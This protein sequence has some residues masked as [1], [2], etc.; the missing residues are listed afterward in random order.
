MLDLLKLLSVQSESYGSDDM[1][2]FIMEYLDSINVNYEYDKHQNIYAVIDPHLPFA[3]AHMDTVHKIF[4]G[5]LVPVEIDGNITGMNDRT[6]TQS[7]IGGDDK[8]GIYAALVLLTEG[9]CNAAFFVDEEVGCKGSNKADLS[10]FKHTPYVLQADRR[11]NSDFITDISGAISSQAFQSA[12]KPY[13]KE[14]GYKFGWGMM[15]DVEALSDLG[16]GVSVANMSCGYYNPHMDNEYINIQDLENC[17]SLMR[18][19]FTNVKRKFKFTRPR[20]KYSRGWDDD[21]YDGVYSTE[22]TIKGKYG[23][24]AYINNN[25]E[26]LTVGYDKY[27]SYTT[28]PSEIQWTEDGL[29]VGENDSNI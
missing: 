15:T 21:M 8:C 19:I 7:G 2:Q 14:H 18:A 3:V 17:I 12:I 20:R 26:R 10:Y 27:F 28:V 5:N 9:L 16:I 22:G 1:E 13:V 25:W 6:M 4:K 23:R 24:Y 11:G 29:F